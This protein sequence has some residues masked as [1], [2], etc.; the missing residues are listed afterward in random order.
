MAFTLT[1]LGLYLWWTPLGS[2]DIES[3]QQG[4]YLLPLLPLLAITCD[5]RW[6]PVLP[7]DGRVT[8]AV[9]VTALGLYATSGWVI[10]T[11]FYGL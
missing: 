3:I 4:R 1:C 8:L 10:W 9:V 6:L 11:R 5:A 2:R 7:R